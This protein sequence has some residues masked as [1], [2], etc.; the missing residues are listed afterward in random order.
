VDLYALGGNDQVTLTGGGLI[1]VV[2]HGG[3]GNDSINASVLT[4]AVSAYGDGGNDSI[5]GGLGNDSLSG[6]DGND[7][8]IGNGGEDL[9]NGDAGGDVLD[10]GAGNDALFGGADADDLIPGT[11]F[12]LSPE[13]VDGG[14][15]LD[16]VIFNF[17]GTS[18]LMGR[19]AGTLN[20]GELGAT[21]ATAFNATD[22][23]NVLAYINTTVPAATGF[24]M[25]IQDLTGSQVNFVR[26][27]FT[28][29]ADANTL[30]M[31]GTNGDDNISADYVLPP[32]GEPVAGVNLP[33]G[34]VWAGSPGAATILNTLAIQ[35]DS[36][37]DKI[38]VAAD[39]SQGAFGWNVRLDGGDGNDLLSA[40][41]T[42]TGG[43]GNDTLIASGLGD[44]LDGGAG[45]DLFI[46]PAGTNTVNGGTGFDTIQVDGTNGGDTISVNQAGG[47]ATLAVN[48]SAST[49]TVASIELIHVQGLMGNDTV[50]LTGSDT[51]ATAD[52]GGDGTDRVNATG[53]A[54]ATSLY[55]GSG[56]DTIT[57]GSAA[58]YLD[59][60]DGYD[61][62]AGGLGN[63]SIEGGSGSD[64]ITYNAGDGQDVVDG[65]EGN[66]ILIVNGLTAGANTFNAYPISGS[67]TEFR[68][69]LNGL[70]P[71]VS[72]ASIQGLNLNG[73]T[74]ADTFNIADMT[75]TSLT[76]VTVNLGVDTVAD[77]V[78]WTGTASDDS[79]VVGGDASNNVTVGGLTVKA[80]VQNAAFGPGATLVDTVNVDGSLGSDWMAASQTLGAIPVKVGLSGGWG[81]DELVAAAPA[82]GTLPRVTLNGG[83]NDDTFILAN[84]NNVV[85]GS[86]GD[87]IRVDGTANNDTITAGGNATTL[88]LNVN[89][90]TSTNDITAFSGVVHVDAMG[91]N[92][93]VTAS[94][95][96]IATSIM[97]GDGN[98]TVD[99]SGMTVAV[100]L[101]G[102]SG[103][104]SI[105]GGSQADSMLGESGNDTI[106]GGLGNDQLSGGDDSDTFVWNN[107]DG[108][109]TVEGGS[110]QNVQIFN[111]SATLADVINLTAASGRVV[112]SRTLPTAVTIDMAGVQTL[113][114][115]TL[116]GGDS[117][118]VNSLAGTDMQLVNIAPGADADAVIV[119]GTN[120]A[121]QISAVIDGTNV[122]VLGLVPVVDILSPTLADT[123][124]IN[125]LQGDD[126]IKS[127]LGVDSTIGVV[128]SGDEGNDTLSGDATLLG[129]AGNDSFVVPLGTNT[130]DGGAGNDTILV[131]GSDFADTITVTQNATVDISV[132]S[133]SVPTTSV[134]TVSNVEVIS[135]SA[136]AGDDTILSN[137]TGTIATYIHGGD[138]NDTINATSLLALTTIYGGSGNDT[139]TGGTS[140]DNI[141]GEAGQDVISGGIGND[142]LFG[143][144]DSDLFLWN[145]GD[146]ND[147]TD[148][149]SGTDA[150]IATGTAGSD[151]LDIAPDN[152]F[153]TQARVPVEVP[154]STQNGSILAGNLEH[155]SLV[156]GAGADLFMVNA[157]VPTPVTAVDIDMGAGAGVEDMAIVK[158]SNAGNVLTATPSATNATVDVNGL[159]ALVRLYNTTLD[160]LLAIQ[161]GYGDDTISVSPQTL[162]LIQV[163]VDG[164]GGD[165]LIKG[166][167]LAMG[168]DGND[169]LIGTPGNDT[170]AG[171]MGDDSISGLAGNDLLLGD[172]VSNGGLVGLTA[173]FTCSGGETFIPFALLP[174]TSEDGGNDTI[175]GGTGNDEIQGNGGDDS[176]LTGTGDDTVHGG[177]GNDYIEG[178]DGNDSL[179]GGP[180]TTEQ[181]NAALD[182]SDTI[183]GGNGNDAID[184]NA[185][186]D[187]LNGGTGD[188]QLW[189]EDGND[190]LGVFVYNGVTQYEPGNDSMV[191]GSGDDV[192]AGAL[193]DAAG[194]PVNDGNDIIFGQDGNDTLWGGGG[195]D[196]IYGGNGEDV[197]L[198]GTPLTANTLHARRNPRLPND[199]ND[200]ML[201]GDGFDRVDGGNGNNLLD[202]GD[203]GIRETILAGLGNDMAYNHMYTDPTTYD[204]FALDGGFNHKFH[205]GGLLEPPVPAASCDYI[206]W[207]IDSM[208]LTGWMTQPDGTVVEHPPLSYRTNLQNGPNGGNTVKIP[209]KS[210]PKPAAKPKTMAKPVAKALPKPVTKITARATNK[211]ANK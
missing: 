18:G 206:T 141:Y 147:T 2:A 98:D 22:V 199:G 88:N 165:D 100:T 30:T 87:V 35:G 8:L 204:I 188:D 133:G 11:Y 131:A 173:N 159:S 29:P 86:A 25:T 182:G 7:T 57:G 15:G 4:T 203:D 177:L 148:G 124:T 146:G 46:V 16:Q 138:G 187:F 42:I 105:T 166:S 115:N 85:I 72:A 44:S 194:Q 14:S 113:N 153:V 132:T 99:A 158:T 163:Q 70:V 174:I 89:G 151:C 116:A 127:G 193:V 3:D 62:L 66:N 55:G 97:G 104:D 19:T 6:G 137:G 190:T 175:L 196:M 45:D 202:A 48:A 9:I 162:T 189:G 76:D 125:G 59:G 155:V 156:G 90:A 121:D 79:I 10:G 178:N 123:L 49:N 92:D 94:G 58:D 51:S 101:Y 73:G 161:G 172:A 69:D 112:L 120:T 129:G 75:G 34:T 61:Y 12:G 31:D 67:P 1:A 54:A 52:D 210:A 139:L 154:T 128:L 68:V 23:E 32:G 118:T 114:V 122:K 200:T 117:V 198:G 56:D 82:L 201:G 185:G 39:L 144:D 205:N 126:V 208:Y 41:A 119:N 143:G 21:N 181:V 108:S 106:T 171:G 157:L 27:N 53:Y 130:I 38:K 93:S 150:F 84:G 95:Y 142:Q 149:G 65:G 192:I 109:D 50:T 77:T 110:G 186:D 17:T 74:A 176:I 111:G 197:M 152:T 184:G 191:G 78:N 64:Q 169:T 145:P 136:L 160:D 47:V 207:T 91:G 102:G 5:T 20:V 43:A 36:G 60:G 180:D 170:L 164:G 28:D 80:T 24:D 183:F 40:D 83:G 96:L 107:G 81:M 211:P 134:N 63:D 103:D 37:D 26:V 179:C 135:I 195:G 168:G 140:V 167:T 71:A 209:V 33:W 13:Y